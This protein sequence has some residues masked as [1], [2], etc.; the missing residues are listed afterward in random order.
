LADNDAGATASAPANGKKTNRKPPGSS[1]KATSK[2]AASKKATGPA[3]AA[4]K[5]SAANGKAAAAAPKR[6]PAA[7][8]KRKVRTAEDKLAENA[9]MA[10]PFFVETGAEWNATDIGKEAF[11]RHGRSER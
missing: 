5:K 3:S 8:T 11:R 4:K 2:K 6:K 9:S 1:K 7:A 10:Q